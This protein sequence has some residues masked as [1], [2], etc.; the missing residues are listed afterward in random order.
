MKMLLYTLDPPRGRCL[1]LARQL[2][3]VTS[4]TGSDCVQIAEQLFANQHPHDNPVSIDVPE[5]ESVNDLKATCA[6]LGIAVE[7]P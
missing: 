1:L 3:Q 4:L 5:I 2:H 7:T 6:G